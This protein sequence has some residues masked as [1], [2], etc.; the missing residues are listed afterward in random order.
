MYVL[1]SDP[2]FDPFMRIIGWRHKLGRTLP[3]TTQEIFDFVSAQV[4]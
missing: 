1:S 4:V 3:K 2:Q